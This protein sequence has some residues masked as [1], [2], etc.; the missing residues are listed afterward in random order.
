MR[1]AKLSGSVYKFICKIII[2]K[3]KITIEIIYESRRRTLRYRK[4]NSRMGKWD[5]VT[6][7]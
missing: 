2:I 7:D 6:G 3:G 5:L 1:N 4:R